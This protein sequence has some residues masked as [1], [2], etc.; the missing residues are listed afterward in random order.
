MTFNKFSIYSAVSLTEN[1]NNK[2]FEKVLKLIEQLNRFDDENSVKTYL[3][4]NFG[5]QNDVMQLAITSNTLIS[6]QTG[7]KHY[8]VTIEYDKSVKSFNFNKGAY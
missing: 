8:N 5:I 2:D 3:R 4:E 1:K 7:R 6:A